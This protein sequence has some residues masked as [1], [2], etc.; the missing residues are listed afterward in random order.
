MRHVSEEDKK[1]EL[2]ILYES[3]YMFPNDSSSR[4]RRRIKDGSM[5]TKRLFD[6]LDLDGSYK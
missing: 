1:E 5:H 2:N 6:G 3:P 4:I